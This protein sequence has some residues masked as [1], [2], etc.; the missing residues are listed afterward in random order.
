MIWR[1][2]SFESFII[3]HKENF[4]QQLFVRKKK[5]SDSFFASLSSSSLWAR[6]CIATVYKLVVTS[7]A[8]MH[9]HV[10]APDASAHC[11]AYN[12]WRGRKKGNQLITRNTFTKSCLRKM[13]K[14]KLNQFSSFFLF[15]FI[16]ISFAF[17]N[18]GQFWFTFIFGPYFSFASV[19]C[20]YVIICVQN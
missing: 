12:V 2:R 18:I 9:V 13:P 10:P 5:K 15:F 20:Y 1:H 6:E 14:N 17:W 4:N 19:I 11:I 3:F 7:S 16:H 8:F